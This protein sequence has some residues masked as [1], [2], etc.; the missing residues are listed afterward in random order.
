LS[1]GC[2]FDEDGIDDDELE[3]WLDELVDEVGLDE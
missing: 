2:R 3:E 1:C